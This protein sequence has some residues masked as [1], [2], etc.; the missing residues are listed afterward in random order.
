MKLAS[1]VSYG[2]IVMYR[3]AMKRVDHPLGGRDEV[4]DGK[5]GQEPINSRYAKWRS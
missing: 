5:D 3:D 4:K 1:M 2:A